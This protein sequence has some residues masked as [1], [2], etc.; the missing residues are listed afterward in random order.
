MV[1]L[2]LLMAG[3]TMLAFRATPIWEELLGLTHLVS[4]LILYILLFWVVC[5]LV[6]T[7]ALNLAGRLCRQ[8]FG[9]R[10]AWL[11]LLFWTAA[12]WLVAVGI[13]GLTLWSFDNGP[14]W[15]PLLALAGLLAL[16]NYTLLVPYLV[17][18]SVNAFYRER[19]K[20]LLRL[21][22]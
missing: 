9:L 20:A 18:S 8:K 4:G 22:V 19:L 10:R 14:E 3:S 1:A 2:T 17:L 12:T 15:L 5:G 16:L 11:W 7:S 21:P 13:L 6:T